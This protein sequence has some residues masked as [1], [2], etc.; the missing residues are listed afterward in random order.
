MA[1][2][3]VTVK[4]IG[5][6]ELEKAFRQSP[7]IVR[8]AIDPAIRKAILAIQARAITKIPVDRGELRNANVPVF[9][10]LKGVLENRAPYAI[11]VHEGTRPHFPPLHAIERWANR[12]GINPY[13][14]ARAI[15]KKGTKGIPFYDDAVK[16]S[17]PLIDS[18]FGQALTNITIK[19]AK[20]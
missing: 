10:T 17:N 20:K 2:T 7:K 19:L 3:P 18:I 15:S 14:V 11:F 13:L 4:V 5:Q 9:S 6:K 1:K 12:H 8:D 16:D